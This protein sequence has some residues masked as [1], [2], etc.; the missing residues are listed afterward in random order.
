MAAMYE[1]AMNEF[2]FFIGDDDDVALVPVWEVFAFKPHSGF[3]LLHQRDVFNHPASSGT[4]GCHQFT[5]K[6][7]LVISRME[8]KMDSS[9][10]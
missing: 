6:E 5:W 9:T 2:G 10:L 7:S 4:N 3:L 1:K 8:L